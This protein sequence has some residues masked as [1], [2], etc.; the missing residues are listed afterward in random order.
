MTI[1]N[2]IMKYLRIDSISI[3][4]DEKDFLC[5][6]TKFEDGIFT[7]SFPENIQLA[8]N[9]QFVLKIKY[10][11]HDETENC[12]VTDMGV[13]YFSS[14]MKGSNLEKQLFTMEEKKQ[15][16]GRRKEPRISVNV[17]NVKQIGLSRID[18]KLILSSSQKQPCAI[19]DMSIH[20][21]CI[22]TYYTKDLQNKELYQ[23]LITTTT[24][25]FIL[26]LHKVHSKLTKV[27][28]NTFAYISC[29]LLEPINYEWQN[30][31]ISYLEKEEKG[32]ISI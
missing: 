32:L 18:H 6:L 29:Q 28:K 23:L 7:F 20:G 3:F 5:A 27:S 26:N 16:Y 31:I 19:V 15:R 8:P 14:T 30:L 12:Y 13:N 22:I 21:I 17:A 1:S 9:S 2:D 24:K 25:Q 4:Q 11:D 10:Q